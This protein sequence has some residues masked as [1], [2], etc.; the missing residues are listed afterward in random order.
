MIHILDKPEETRYWIAC[1][2]DHFSVVYG[3]THPQQRTETGQE[4]FHVYKT[5]S[6]RN[7]ILLNDFGITAH[8][9]ALTTGALRGKI[10]GEP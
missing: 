9:I 8:E 10:N 5:E 7:E 3:E 6:A 2:K 1:S 4:C